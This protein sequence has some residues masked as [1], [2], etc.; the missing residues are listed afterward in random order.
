MLDLDAIE[1]DASIPDI[2]GTLRLEDVTILNLCQENRAMRTAIRD[3][4]S[5]L[6]NGCPNTQALAVLVTY[7]EKP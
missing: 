2:T 5:H 6:K 1:R 7:A 4:I 3:A